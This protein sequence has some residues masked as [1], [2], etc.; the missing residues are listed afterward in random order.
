MTRSRSSWRL[1]PA[2][3]VV[4]LAATVGSCSKSDD[5]ASSNAAVPGTVATP[6]ATVAG[7]FPLRVVRDV[8]LPGATTRLDYQDIDASGRRL[9]VA[10]LGDGTIHVIDLD[11]LSV[12]TTIEGV[13]LVHGVRVAPDL[14]RLLASATGSNEVVAIDTGTN[15]IVGRSATGKFPD[16]IAVDPKS[17]KAYVSNEL[18]HVETVIDARTA[19]S[20]AS[21]DIGGEGGNTAYDSG[22][23]HVLVNVQ[24]QGHVAIIDPASDTIVGTIDTPG[25]DVNHSLYVDADNRLAFVAC[26]G[27]A[28]LLVIDLDSK[29]VTGTFDIGATPDVFAFDYGLHRLY[30]ACESGTV[31]VFDEQGKGLRKLGETKLAD[32]SH[33]VAVDQVTHRVFFPLE[34]VDGHPTLRIMEPT[35]RS[36]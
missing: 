20:V 9:Y 28:K 10:H 23:G 32:S 22:T 36:G 11:K 30:I 27:N 12:L 31:S 33:T 17:G 35:D 6:G 15:A 4:A 5:A 16:G 26:Q 29:A 2:V 3:A 13:A 7:G 14:H 34:N 18:D 25:C 8:E 19:A 21:I 24:D 1:L